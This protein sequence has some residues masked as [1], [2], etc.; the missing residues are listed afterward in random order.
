MERAEG[1]VGDGRCNRDGGAAD[2]LQG[3]IVEILAEEYP[4]VHNGY[5]N[6]DSGYA[7]VRQ[8]VADS[9]KRRGGTAFE[10]KNS[11][12]TVGAAGGRNVI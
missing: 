7:D 10:G 8:T 1:V 11:S 3:A 12:M 4:V 5:T 2:W 6:S 9:L